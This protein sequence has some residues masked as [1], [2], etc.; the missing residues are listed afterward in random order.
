MPRLLLWE[1]PLLLA[2]VYLGKSN[3]TKVLESV[4]KVLA[5]LG[6]DVVGMD[7]SSVGF[8]VVKWGL[9]LDHVVEV[10]VHARTVFRS[11]KALEDSKR[12]EE[13]AKVAYRIVVGEDT[14]FESTYSGY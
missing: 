1:T 7:S 3:M 2:Q 14:S 4:G 5:A 12:A 6:F 11:L 8:R 9:V 13:Y 10:F